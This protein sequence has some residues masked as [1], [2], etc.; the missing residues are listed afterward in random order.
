M[1]DKEKKVIT[2]SD[3]VSS[4]NLIGEAKINDYTYKIDE[5]SEKSAWRYNS[6]NLG[7]DCGEKHGTVYCELMGGFSEEQSNVIYAHG[8]KEDGRDDFQT[9]IQVDW[10]DRFNPDILET[11]GDLSFITVGL[12]LTDK[13]KTF[14]KR[15]LSAYDA[16]AYIK[17]H[18]EDGTVVNIRGNLKYS[19]YQD[20]VQVRKNITSIVLSKVDDTSKYVARFTQSVLLNKDSANLKNVDKDKGVLYIDTIVLDYLKELNGVEIK[21]QY[22]YKKQFEYIF[23]DLSNEKQCKTIMDKVFKVKK[24]VTQ[25]TFEGEF[26]EGGATITATLD[27]IP[28]DIKDLIECGVFTE[29]EALAR[30]SSNGNRE[31]HMILKKP[32]IRLVG[33]EKKPVTQKFEG[34][35]KEEDL[36]LDYLNDAINQEVANGMNPPEEAEEGVTE[37]GG[38]A[39]DM[40]WLNNL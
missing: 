30:C 26:V 18:L 33:D 12:E 22:P 37:D 9:Q 25:I 27:D 4:F 11:V 1:A 14:Y 31:Q 21:G 15:F 7:V 39:D 8:K 10:E 24:D 6:L 23:P 16:I 2:R 40:S 38:A 34:K 35:Y 5:K 17:E 32:L 19:T 36:V 28:D 29:E 13:E 20:K 3:W